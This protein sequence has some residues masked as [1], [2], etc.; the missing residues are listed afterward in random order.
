MLKRFEQTAAA[1]AAAKTPFTSVVGLVRTMLALATAG[2]LA[3]TDPAAIFS[4]AAEVMEIPPVCGDGRFASLFCTLPREDLAIMRWSA[5]VLLLVVASGWR[6]RITGLLHVWVAM[7]LQVSGVLVDGGDQIASNLA[8]LLLPLTLA[9]AR[10]WHW[11][12]DAASVPVARIVGQV[13]L[14]AARLQVAGVYFHA[15]AGKFGH[16]EW[17]D[18]T[19]VY[20]WFTHPFFGAPGWLRG[21]LTS[22]LEVGV[23]V[24]SIAWGT[25][26]LEFFLAAAPWL[27]RAT[28]RKLFPL[29]VALHLGIVLIHGLV[30]FVTTM[31]GALILLL[32]TPSFGSIRE[33]LPRMPPFRDEGR[34]A[35]DASLSRLVVQP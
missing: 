15:A 34:P 11:A 26:V 10:R 16:E 9:D 19:A 17:A 32:V 5:V 8:L 12:G 23:I 13:S 1:V 4:P 2:T 22:A 24:A 27:P 6:P 29:G 35:S 14:F 25:I 21:P 31:W 7:S 20:Y 28:Q 18:G 30:S 33:L 3:A